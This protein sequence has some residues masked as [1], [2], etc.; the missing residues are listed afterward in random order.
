MLAS[1]YYT[2]LLTWVACGADTSDLAALFGDETE[3][4][5]DTHDDDLAGLT[6]AVFL[7]RHLGRGRSGLRR[8]GMVGK[9]LATAGRSVQAVME[10][11]CQS[12]SEFA[13]RLDLGPGVCRPLLQ[14]F[15]RW[16]GRGVPGEVEH[17][18][19]A[20]AIRLV[21][22][23]DAVE[24]FH[25]SGGAG[26]AIEVAQERRGTQF[27]PE[28]VDRFCDDHETILADLDSISAWD[29]VI[30]L[31]P[32]LGDALD[33]AQLDRGAR[34]ARR[35]RRPQVAAPARS[36]TRRRRAVGRRRRH[37]RAP[38]SRRRDGATRRPRPR[39]GDDRG[40]ERGVGRAA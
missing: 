36:L 30:A 14:A 15:E 31:D 28:L 40:A 37:D 1:A 22:L 13:D 16:D 35:L 6:M 18:G 8:I 26:A 21:H 32:R 38:G 9:F 24:A 29:E 17:D 20:P 12:A 4:F 3:L 10:S 34:G 5:A 2:S 33:D 11:H 19:L 7:A 39:R 25:H 27:D 23:A